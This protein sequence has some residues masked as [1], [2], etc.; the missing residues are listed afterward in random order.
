MGAT[1][2]HMMKHLI[3][4]NST[5][6]IHLVLCESCFWSATMLNMSEDCV[7]PTCT[8]SNVSFIPL[9]LDESS[10]LSMS[11]KSW[12]EASLSSARKGSYS[13]FKFASNNSRL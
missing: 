5:S 6:S 9:S 7:C 11:T 3:F 4:D 13:H 10:R 1:T 2:T 8:D 12:L